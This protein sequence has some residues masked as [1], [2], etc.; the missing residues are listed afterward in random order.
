MQQQPGYE[1][2][3]WE[4]HHSAK[5]DAPSGTLLEVGR[6]H[7]APP[8][9]TQHVDVASSRAGAVPGTARNR[10]RLRRRH[11]HPAPHR[12]QP[13]GLR[14]RS[15]ARRQWISAN[16]GVHEFSEILFSSEPQS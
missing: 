15:P 5:K 7:D 10:L 9:T 13:R 14:P 12:P 6:R 16:K 8:A 1:A 4:I 3:A 11:H 2:W